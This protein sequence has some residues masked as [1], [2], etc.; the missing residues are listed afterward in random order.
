MTDRDQPDSLACCSPLCFCCG[1]FF[2][3]ECTQNASSPPQLQLSNETCCCFIHYSCPITVFIQ[4]WS[5]LYNFKLSKRVTFKIY[6]VFSLLPLVHITSNTSGT[7][8][9]E[10]KPVSSSVLWCAYANL[11]KRSR[12]C[13]NSQCEFTRTLSPPS[14]TNPVLHWP[15]ST[16]YHNNNSFSLKTLRGLSFLVPPVEKLF[17][18]TVYMCPCVLY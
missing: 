8:C 5:Y 10:R 13:N 7:Q 16:L 15:Y 17:S 4:E 6:S 14:L 18:M 2:P 9:L 11:L 1:Q 3:S 12:T